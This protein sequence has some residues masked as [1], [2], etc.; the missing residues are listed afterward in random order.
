[1]KHTHLFI[2]PPPSPL[3]RIRAQLMT[4]VRLLFS[5]LYF[6]RRFLSRPPLR[7]RP[8]RWIEPGIDHAEVDHTA[9]VA[10][11]V[12]IGSPKE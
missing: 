2:S 10:V 3:P 5:Q 12:G 4:L 1:M 9:K 7:P 8:K 6:L 11:R